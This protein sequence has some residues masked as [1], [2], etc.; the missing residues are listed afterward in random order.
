M[1]PHGHFT[2][3]MDDFDQSRQS[4][5]LGLRLCVLN[6]DLKEG[7]VVSRAVGKLGVDGGELLVRGE[8]GR[9]NIVAEQERVGHDVVELDEGT[10]FDGTSQFLIL[11]EGGRGHNNPVVIGVVERI[12]G[13]LLAWFILECAMGA[14][15]G[16]SLPWEE[17]LPSS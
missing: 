12:S 14:L 6:L 9:S 15:A 7:V 8:L 4:P 11:G 1:G 5:K 10:I 13:H 2:W 3:V 16:W 17:T